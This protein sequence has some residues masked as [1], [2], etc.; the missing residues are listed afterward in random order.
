MIYIIAILAITNIVSI[1][2]CYNLLKQVEQVEDY[3]E[4]LEQ[5]IEFLK[6]KISEAYKTI[7]EADIKGSFEADDEV[8]T[9]FNNIKQAVDYLQLLFTDTDNNA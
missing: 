1:Y 4:S 9:I 6:D 8:G 7:K 5:Y 3:N 2:A